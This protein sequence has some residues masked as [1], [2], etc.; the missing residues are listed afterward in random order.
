MQ[1]SNDGDQKQSNKEK[2][3]ENRRVH[4]ARTC[5]GIG[6][7]GDRLSRACNAHGEFHQAV[8]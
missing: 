3:E 5:E 4:A 2:N 1:F 7:E 8:G 6:S